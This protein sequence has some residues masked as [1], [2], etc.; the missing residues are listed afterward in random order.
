MDY[1][2][3]SFL[4]GVYKLSDKVISLLISFF[5]ILFGILGR[6]SPVCKDISNLL[7]KSLYAMLKFTG[8]AAVKH[9]CYVVCR[10][11]HQ[12]YHFR[13]CLVLSFGSKRCTY[14]AFPYHPQHIMR[15][16][17]NTLLLKT[18]ELASGKSIAYPF[19]TYCYLSIVSSMERFLQQPTFYSLCN[20][21]RKREVPE[22]L[23]CDVFDGRMWKEFER[24]GSLFFS[25][26]F[27]FGF[28]INV[29]WFQPYKH[30]Q[31]SVGVVFLTVLNLPRHLRNKRNN[32]MLIGIIPGPHEPSKNIK[33][34][35]ASC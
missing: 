9:K 21:W 4:Q 28:M 13:D 15:Q 12:I 35:R 27:S 16:P 14:Q 23:M 5:H 10:K 1:Q 6:F 2:L 22:D 11:C 33:F 26:T 3:F 8:S 29:D 17:C 24:N 18:V 34:P 32:V 30:T 31:Y 7:P 25:D 19:M 20:E